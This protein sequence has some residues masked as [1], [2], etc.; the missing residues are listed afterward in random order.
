MKS[1]LIVLS[2]LVITFSVQSETQTGSAIVLGTASIFKAGTSSNTGFIACGATVAQSSGTDAVL[3]NLPEGTD[4][5]I[6]FG[7]TGVI[8]C[9]N[10][11]PDINPDGI[12]A[13]THCGGVTNVFGI[14][15]IKGQA[16]TTLANPI[17]QSLNNY[18]GNHLSG[19]FLDNVNPVGVVNTVLTDIATQTT[20]D[21]VD[22][23]NLSESFFI[24]DGNSDTVANNVQTFIIPTTATR[25]FLGIE[26]AFAISGTPGCY[27]DNNGQFNVEYTITFTP[28]AAIGTEAIPIPSLSWQALG[29]I[30]LGIFLII[31]KSRYRKVKTS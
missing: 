15:G 10:I 18:G 6:T 30:I 20:D 9:L 11:A 26:D 2:L 1:G 25:L 29:L 19:V 12:S 28:L 8:S 13:G 27:Q 7:A 17:S 24:G 23:G 16:V 14:N 5:S 22:I 3:I 21:I 31:L 4:R